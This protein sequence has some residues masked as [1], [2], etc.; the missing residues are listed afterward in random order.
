MAMGGFS[1][2]DAA[3]T[4]DQLKAFIASGELRFVMVGGRGSG[5]PGAPAGAAGG[6][7]GNPG[8]ASSAVADWVSSSCAPVDLGSG[9]SSIFD[10]A[11]A[12]G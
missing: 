2:G 5:G 3:P 8:G 12:A 1:G 9:T 11:A 7:P 10:C 6:S 4:L